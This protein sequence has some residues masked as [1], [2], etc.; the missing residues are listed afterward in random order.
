MTF[1]ATALTFRGVAL[2]P[3]G[4]SHILPSLIGPLE[5]RDGEIKKRR[6]SSFH[7]T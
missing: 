3:Q 4:F 1:R 6:V 7:L 5:P 2:Q